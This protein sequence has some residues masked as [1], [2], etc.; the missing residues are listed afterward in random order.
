MKFAI[1]EE[2]RRE[3]ELG[4][5]GQCPVCGLA[6]LPKCGERRTWHW[7]HRAVRQCDRWWE[8]ETEWHRNWKNNFPIEWQETVRRAENGE[9]HIAD[10]RTA[11]DHIIEFQH[12]FLKPE[13]RRSREAFYGSVVWV[14]NGLRRDRDMPTFYNNLR[15]GRIGSLEPLSYWVPS[16]GC[17]LIRDWSDSCV[18]VFFDFGDSQEDRFRFDMPVLWHMK[19]HGRGRYVLLSPV[20]KI[21]FVDAF[22]KDVPI[23]GF[24]DA[25]GSRRRHVTHQSNQHL[26]CNG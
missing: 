26:H 7:A 5:A 24:R 8:N 4:L 22:V 21:S 17:A 20:S 11:Q 2:N 16:R 9:K 1:V 23:K 25:T 15:A 14:V 19:P 12:S 13:E 18:D 3:A 10:V 6:M